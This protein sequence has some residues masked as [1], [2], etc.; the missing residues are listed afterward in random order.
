MKDDAHGAEAQQ[1]G[2]RGWGGGAAG[3]KFGRSPEHCAQE[4]PQTLRPEDIHGAS[5]G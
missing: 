3:G 5:T 1:G 4:T 2:E